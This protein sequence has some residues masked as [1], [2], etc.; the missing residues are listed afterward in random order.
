[1]RIVIAG[2]GGIGFFLARRL[3]MEKA[4]LV[5]IDDDA[6]RCRS[7]QAL[8]DVPLRAPLGAHATHACERAQKARV[9]A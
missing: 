7:V 5:V 4:N 9:P 8:I 1:M 3:S 2:A 6:E